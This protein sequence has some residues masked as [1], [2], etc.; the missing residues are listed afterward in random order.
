METPVDLTDRIATVFDISGKRV[1]NSKLTSNS[2]NVSKLQSGV[3]LL[4]LETEGKVMT[5]KFIKE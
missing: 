2:L 3:Y 5:K 1:L 4:Q